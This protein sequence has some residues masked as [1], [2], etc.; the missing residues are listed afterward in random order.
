MKDEYLNNIFVS[1]HQNNVMPYFLGLLILLVLI[2]EFIGRRKHIGFW[3]SLILMLFGLIPGLLA[4]AISP[5]AKKH[6]TE[7]KFI[8][9]FGLVLI[10]IIGAPG[11][12]VALVQGFGT[13][14]LIYRAGFSIGFLVLGAYLYLLGQGKIQNDNPKYYYNSITLKG[15]SKQFNKPIPP[16]SKL[17]HVLINED[18]G[19]TKVFNFMEL[20]NCNIISKDTLIWYKGL[21]SWIKAEEIVELRDLVFSIPPPLPALG[22]KKIEKSHLKNPIISVIKYF[23]PYD[24]GWLFLSFLFLFIVL[25]LYVAFDIQSQRLGR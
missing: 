17:Y 25:V 23:E 14:F 20:Q 21:S 6:T 5:S 12:I 3:W 4:I 19:E 1:M 8:Q 24:G 2:A 15:N 10:I 16:E 13:M 7:N 9:Y 22:E 18:I 11:L